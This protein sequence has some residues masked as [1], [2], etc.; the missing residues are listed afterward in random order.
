[1]GLSLGSAVRHSTNQGLA[2]GA[3]ALAR[4]LAVSAGAHDDLVLLQSFSGDGAMLSYDGSDSLSDEIG[5]KY[6]DPDDWR[7][8]N[9]AC[10]LPLCSMTES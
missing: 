5:S 8:N 3:S 1:M 4:L 9:S 6:F 2:H 10:L 7:N